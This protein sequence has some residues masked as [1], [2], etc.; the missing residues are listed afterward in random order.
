MFL[1]THNGETAGPAPV[2]NK[3]FYKKVANQLTDLLSTYTAAGT[4]Y[5]VDLRLRPDGR[6]G[7]VAISL[8]GAKTYYQNRARDWELQ[9][10]IKARVS[11]GDRDLGWRCW[12][13]WSR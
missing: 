6:L 9:M 8:D 11:A 13:S 1:Y 2:T 12:S 3:E 10:L 4:A 5:R 7:E